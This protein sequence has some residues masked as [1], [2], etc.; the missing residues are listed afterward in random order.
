M[1]DDTSQGKKS[2]QD[3]QDFPRD[4]ED[5]DF[6][7]L[8]ALEQ[9]ENAGLPGGEDLSGDDDMI[10]L[11]VDDDDIMFGE[12]DSD[13]SGGFSFDANISADLEEEL[14]SEDAEENFDASF[15]SDLLEDIQA[16]AD[17]SFSIA[18]NEEDVS[19]D[20]GLDLDLDDTE[21]DMSAAE[22][23]ALKFNHGETPDIEIETP[24]EEEGTDL[25]E[26]DL[27]FGH[28]TGASLDEEIEETEPESL[29]DEGSFEE[30]RFSGRV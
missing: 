15:G 7:I 2:Q 16:T 29:L 4:E 5:V 20:D 9:L 24:E 19:I 8:D 26:Y 25:G 14:L 18:L 3:D 17:E 23:L 6:E 27:V 11:T 13:E 12:D 30:K 10:E 28:S 1:K 21:F 22:T